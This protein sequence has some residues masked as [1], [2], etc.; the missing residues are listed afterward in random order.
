M[1]KVIRYFLVSLFGLMLSSLSQARTVVVIDAGHGGKDP[2]AIGKTLGIKEKEV[3]LSISKELKA[4]L[5]ADPNFKAVMTRNSDVFIQLPERTEIAR[6]NK[7]N[8]LVSIHADSSPISSEVKGASVWVLSN[9]RASDEMGKWLEESEKQSEL[10]G[11]AGRILSNNN[12]RYLNQTVLDLQ[13]SHSQR[14]GY[15]LGKTVLARMAN[16]TT[17]AKSAPQHASLSVLRS[18]DITSILVETGFLS[19]PVEEKKLSTA[20]YRKQLAKAI[21]NGLVA[22]RNSH[23]NIS[24]SRASNVKVKEVKES[25]KDKDKKEDTSKDTPKKPVKEVSTKEKKSTKAE[26]AKDIERKSKEKD[27]VKKEEKSERKQPQKS[28]TGYHLVQQDE[29]LY[30]IARVYGTTPEK[31]SQLNNIKN[32]QIVVGKKLKVQ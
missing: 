8:Y 24:E 20:S 23:V 3:T 1:K 30:S 32:N 17:L 11:G 5:D 7:A 15:E 2:G 22:Y 4:L 25:K 28:N 9:Q 21:Y 18:P 6:K 27:E 29:T 10:L 19:N 12:E 31:L 13:F 16:M 26:N 14:A